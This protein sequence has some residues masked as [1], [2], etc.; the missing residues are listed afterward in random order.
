[1]VDL[2][3]FCSVF[4]S[5][6]PLSAFLFDQIIM[7]NTACASGNMTKLFQLIS[8]QY[9]NTNIAT[10]QRKY[11]NESKGKQNIN[12]FNRVSVKKLL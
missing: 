1:M 9:H 12:R 5:E 3:L 7:P 11:F 4:L 8:D 6:K 2:D 10:V